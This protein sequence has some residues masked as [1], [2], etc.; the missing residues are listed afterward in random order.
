MHL[1]AIFMVGSYNSVPKDVVYNL[2]I[3]KVTLFNS[4]KFEVRKYRAG[5]FVQYQKN[6]L[7][8]V[9]YEMN[10]FLKKACFFLC[11]NQTLLRVNTEI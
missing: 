1:L 5:Q 11:Y 4:S 9:N 8:N 7:V 10:N 3:K 6:V 2:V